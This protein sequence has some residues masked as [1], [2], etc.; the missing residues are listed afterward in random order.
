MTSEHR[1]EILCADD[2]RLASRY[3]DL[4]HAE[5]Q[6]HAAE[7]DHPETEAARRRILDFCTGHRGETTRQPDPS[8]AEGSRT[9]GSAV[10]RSGADE[11][12]IGESGFGE[13]GSG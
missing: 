1:F 5:A 2:P 4:A 10:A 8:N 13:S 9:D 7:L 12:G 6:L 11:T 3:D